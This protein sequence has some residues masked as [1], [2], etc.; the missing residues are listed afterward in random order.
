MGK[1]VFVVRHNLCRAFYFGHTKKSLFVVRFLYG[2]W[3]RKKR[4]PNKLFAVRL[5]NNARRRSC[6]SCVVF[7]A[8]GK[9]FFS[10]T[11]SE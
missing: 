6:L 5:E 10:L 11:H 1:P 3:Q 2:A 9:V 8:H 4:T 7:I